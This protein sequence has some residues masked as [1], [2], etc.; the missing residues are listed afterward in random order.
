M[1]PDSLTRRSGDLPQNKSDD[2]KRHQ[3]QILLKAKHLEK[4]V[5]QALNL[6]PLLLDE[7]PQTVCSLA[8]MVY[9]L[10]ERDSDGEELL[11]ESPPAAPEPSV[12]EPI[13]ESTDDSITGPDIMLRVKDLYEKDDALQRIMH[14]KRVGQRRIP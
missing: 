13:E 8:A 1:K 11:E 5:Q 10:G 7:I 9:D 4:G 3:Q 2:R 14:A 12:E 6:A